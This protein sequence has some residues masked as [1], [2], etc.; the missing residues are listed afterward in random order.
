MDYTE[1]I[2]NE[3]LIFIENLC[4]AMCVK[5]VAQL[6]MAA[7]NKFITVT[8]KREV[9]REKSYNKHDLPLFVEENTLKLLQ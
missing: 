5:L 9:V 3:A 8:F 2:Y 6:G 1:E 4:L 7:E